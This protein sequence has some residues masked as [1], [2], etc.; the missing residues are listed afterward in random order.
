MAAGLAGSFFSDIAAG[1][2]SDAT[3]N[4]IKR[5]AVQS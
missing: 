2:V 5:R 1:T 3:R 4:E